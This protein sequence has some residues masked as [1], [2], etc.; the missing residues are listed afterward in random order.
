MSRLDSKAISEARNN[1]LTRF[2][3]LYATS[4][5]SEQHWTTTEKPTLLSQRAGISFTF[6]VEACESSKERE[7]SLFSSFDSNVIRFCV[8]K[9]MNVTT[10]LHAVSDVPIVRLWWIIVHSN[11]LFFELVNQ[12]VLLGFKLS[13]FCVAASCGW[14]LEQ[15]DVSVLLWDGGK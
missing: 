6:S 4:I 13:Y 2:C 8:Y 1:F 10:W 15:R 7:I 11:H 14:Q 9:K 5:R 3:V 12:L